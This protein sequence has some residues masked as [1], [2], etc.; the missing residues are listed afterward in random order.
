M[1]L[2]EF[3]LQE[4]LS[5]SQLAE[6]LGRPVSTVHGWLHGNRRPDWKSLR[7]IT[8]ATSGCVSAADF[9]MQAMAEPQAKSAARRAY[10]PG[11]AETQAPFAAEAQSLGLDATAIAAKA[12]QDAIRAEKAR[13]WLAENEDAIEAWNRWTESNELPLAEYRMF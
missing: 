5:L 6:R 7:Q 11:L 13:R 2:S 1:T 8:E 12:V 10:A 3:Q 4:G 9:E